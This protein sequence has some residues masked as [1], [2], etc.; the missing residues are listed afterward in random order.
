MDRTR[1][2]CLKPKLKLLQGFCV[3]VTFDDVYSSIQKQEL[4]KFMLIRQF[5]FFVQ[6]K[7]G[8]LLFH[9]TELIV[10]VWTFLRLIR[11]SEN[12][13]ALIITP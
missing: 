10:F 11:V 8:I 1:T 2:H 7:F 6:N 9:K 4:I 3:I 13:L 12:E 5:L